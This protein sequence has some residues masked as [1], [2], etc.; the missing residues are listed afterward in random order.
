LDAN[1]STT[2]PFQGGPNHE[3]LLGLVGRWAG[4]TRTWF[5]PSG[6]AFESTTEATIESLFGGRFVRISYA[7]TVPQNP[8]A[9]QMILGFHNDARAFAM[10]WLDSFHTGT[11]LLLSVGEPRAD[12][13]ISVLGSY[14]AGPER[15][16]WRTV[17]RR[18]QPDQLVIEAYNISPAGQEDRAIESVLARV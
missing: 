8:H 10:A 12:G 3:L 16:G 1:L 14:A 7:G 18:P 13:A 17:I 4:P 15:W 11:S 5:D 2:A 6:P 9:G